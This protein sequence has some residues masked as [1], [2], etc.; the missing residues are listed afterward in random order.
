[1]PRVIWPLLHDQPR[2]EI[3]LTR[4]SDSQP[5]IRELLADTGAGTSQSPFDLILETSDC[6]SCGG[7]SGTTIALGGAYN[8][9]FLLYRL[10]VRL[11]ALSFNR[12][13]RVVA[14]PDRP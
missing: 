9:T 12:L 14:V 10:R 13:L 8:G 7:R 1:M 3:V 6:L 4:A 2:I 11:P 5:V